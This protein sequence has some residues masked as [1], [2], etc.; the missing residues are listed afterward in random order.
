MRSQLVGLLLLSLCFA[1]CSRSSLTINA[2]KS[3][4]GRTIHLRVGD[5]VKVSLAENPTTGYKWEFLAKPEPICVVVSDAYVADTSGGRVGS[6]GVHNW[7]FRAV[8][9]GT[10]TVSLGYRRPWEKDVAP[11]QTFTLTIV[12]K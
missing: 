6:G 9:K 3:D 1:G 12:V 10:A 2:D 8:A 4:D 11:A 7:D 5:G